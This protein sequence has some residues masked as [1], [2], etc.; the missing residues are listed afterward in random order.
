MDTIEK[1]TVF[2]SDFLSSGIP[3]A[4]LASVPSV[5]GGT[6]CQPVEMTCTTQE[7]QSLRWYFDERSEAIYVYSVI[8]SF[9]MV[10]HQQNGVTITIV[11]AT[12]ESSQSDIFNGTS[13]LTASTSALSMLDVDMIQCGTNAVRSEAIDLT[14]LNIQRT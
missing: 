5:L 1:C 11:A 7:L 12:P 13:V 14:M 8:N 4:R 2:K 10:I 6:L 9:P 3:Q